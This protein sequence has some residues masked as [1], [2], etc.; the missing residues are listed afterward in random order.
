MPFDLIPDELLDGDIATLAKKGAGK[1][2]LNKGMV[3]RL[4]K[5]KRRGAVLDPLNVWWGL[6]AKADGSPGF[7]VVVIGGPKADVPLDPHKGAELGQFMAGSDMFAVIDVSDLRRGELNTFAAAF[8]GALYK[9][10][11][12]P[13]HLVLEEADIF[14]PQNPEGNESFTLH[15]VDQIARRGRQRGF[16]LWTI[17]QRP[18]QLNKKTLSQTATIILMRLMA[19]QD[20]KAA[21]DWLMAHTGKAEATAIS[22]D[23]SKLLVGEGWVLSP[24]HD[25]LERMNFPPI[26]T[27]DTSATPKA[28]DKLP[29]SIRLAKPDLTALEA[30]LRP[31]PPETPAKASEPAPASPQPAVD[32]KALEAAAFERGRLKGIRQGRAAGKGLALSSALG[33]LRPILKRWEEEA[34]TPEQAVVAAETAPTPPT[35]STTTNVQEISPL[36]DRPPSAFKVVK[37]QPA[38]G[39]PKKSYKAVDDII[40]FYEAIAPR[41]VPFLTAAKQAGVGVR[42]SQFRLYEPL[43]RES[44]RVE[45][46][47]GGRY[48][49]IMLTGNPDEYL[50]RVEAQ[51][52]PKHRLMFRFIRS[53]GRPVPKDELV[54]ACDISPTSSTTAAGIGILMR[55]AEVVEE[56]AGGYQLVEAY[57]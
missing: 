44:G 43:V 35:G 23:L 3:E 54:A 57:R 14:A 41:A 22:G 39:E 2:Y 19:P 12:L 55:E 10:N 25:I 11:R 47:G 42:S 4:L 52:A 48:R 27:L 21:E 50:D 45:D 6:K 5:L 17:C 16:R 15:E 29:E 46:L 18:Q 28:G 30:L 33:D 31:A 37:H 51:L 36:S 9:H 53:A 49:G 24:E 26:E 40:A 7:P 20:R 8:L 1:T 56:V 32:V 34:Y 38:E 13:F